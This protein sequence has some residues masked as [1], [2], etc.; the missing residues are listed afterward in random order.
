M[1]YDEFHMDI[2]P[3]VPNNSVFLTPTQTEIKL[4]HKNDASSYVPKYSNPYKY[5]LWFEEQMEHVLKR[6]KQVFAEMNAVEID[7]VP[8]YKVRTPLQ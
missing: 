7:E 4:T 5:H 1:Q 8:T 2:L 6:H 3:C